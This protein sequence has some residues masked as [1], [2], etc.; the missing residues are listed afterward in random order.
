MSQTVSDCYRLGFGEPVAVSAVTGEGWADLYV[1]LQP[2]IDA[3]TAQLREEAGLPPLDGADAGGAGKGRAVARRGLDEDGEL[4]SGD[5]SPSGAAGDGAGG[6]Q[7]A[8][9]A[10][11]GDVMTTGA[12]GQ[13]DDLDGDADEDA[14]AAGPLRLAIMGLPNVV[15]VTARNMSPE[16]VVDPFVPSTTTLVVPGCRGLLH[17]IMCGV[18]HS[19]VPMTA[20][21]VVSYND[22]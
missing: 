18:C 17:G 15:G 7:R 16:C 8:L 5:D 9:Q 22:C 1:A 3:L 2:R 21:G 20:L 13:A 6:H 4:S 10:E 19:S 14:V 12:G 11:G